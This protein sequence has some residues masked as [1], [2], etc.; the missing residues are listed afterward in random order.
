M[1]EGNGGAEFSVA[2]PPRT[3]RHRAHRQMLDRGCSIGPKLTEDTV[4]YNIVRRRKF[5]LRLL[6]IP[7]DFYKVRLSMR[8]EG[9]GRTRLTVKTTHRGGWQGVRQE[10]ERWIIEGLGGDPAGGR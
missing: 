9:E 7:P 3:V 10:I 8:E 4:E 5:P 2:L 6:A 1:T